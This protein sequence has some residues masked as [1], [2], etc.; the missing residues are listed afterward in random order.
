MI[1]CAFC[2]HFE[3]DRKSFKMWI[4]EIQTASTFDIDINQ[5]S[6]ESAQ[7]DRCVRTLAARADLDEG[8]G[9]L[10]G[11]PV[12]AVVLLQ[13]KHKQTGERERE[14]EISTNAESKHHAIH[15]EYLPNV[16]WSVR[17]SICHDQPRLWLA[18]LRLTEGGFVNCFVVIASR[19]CAEHTM[20]EEDQT[21]V[22]IKTNKQQTNKQTNKQTNQAPPWSAHQTRAWGP[23]TDWF[24]DRASRAWRILPPVVVQENKRYDFAF[25]YFVRINDEMDSAVIHRKR[26]KE[27]RLLG[28]SH[29]V[30]TNAPVDERREEKRREEK[31]RWDEMRM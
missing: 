3:V 21:K 18:V 19:V 31:R 11:R 12:L 16:R 24:H 13:K 5:D 27:T 2:E 10:V 7:Q 29:I 6:N 26:Q 14:N 28:C 23:T 22:L 20:T 9:D 4:L 15:L 17:S 25:L 1:I 30:D 8:D